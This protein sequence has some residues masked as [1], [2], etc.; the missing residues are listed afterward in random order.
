MTRMMGKIA[1]MPLKV[2]W[3][4]MAVVPGL[5][6]P[7]WLMAWI[8]RLDRSEEDTL[9]YLTLMSQKYDHDQVEQLAE[10]IFESQPLGSVA[11]Y[12]GL[13]AMTQGYMEQAA[14]WLDKAKACDQGSP[15]LVLQLE[16]ALSGQPGQDSDVDIASRIIERKDVSMP[17]TRSALTVLAT[18]ALHQRRWQEAEGILDRVFHIED[19]IHLRW[20][21]WVAAAGQGHIQQAQQ[22]FD[23]AW[24]DSPKKDAL[25]FQAYGWFL[26]NE[27]DQ[28]K[29]ALTEALSAGASPHRVQA[30]GQSLGIQVGPLV[31]DFEET[32]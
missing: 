8:W 3:L 29:T 26:L 16:L 10:S 31:A 18:S 28:G 11:A 19:P 13:M 24:K 25:F 1:A 14:L 17:L 9:R 12:A 6:V 21:R 32:R 15:E 2:L 5:H 20:M 22:F 4:I 27:I 23:R 30:L 7:E